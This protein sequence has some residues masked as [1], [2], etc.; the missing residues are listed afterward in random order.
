MQENFKLKL[1]HVPSLKLIITNP[2]IAKVNSRY[3]RTNE[4]GIVGKY[5]Q[6]K[7]K[8]YIATSIY[9]NS[10]VSKGIFINAISLRNQYNFIISYNS[11]AESWD[12][13]KYI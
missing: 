10:I 6:Y 1:K 7:I 9:I 13:Y 11:Y 3:S 5:L 4:D 2:N 12:M 8:K